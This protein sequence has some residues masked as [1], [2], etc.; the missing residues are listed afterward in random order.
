MNRTNVL[1]NYT[2][3]VD[4]RPGDRDLGFLAREP[5]LRDWLTGDACSQDEQAALLDNFHSERLWL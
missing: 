1:R 4:A 2:Y 5:R 3:L